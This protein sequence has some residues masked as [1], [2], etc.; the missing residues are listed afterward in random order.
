M[1]RNKSLTLSI[2][3]AAG[4]FVASAAL[5]QSPLESKAHRL[6]AIS[7]D[8]QA[9]GKSRVIVK[10][11]LPP[12][13]LRTK[14]QIAARKD[15]VRSGQDTVLRA[16]FGS[17]AAAE[18]HAL[19]RM[20]IQPLFALSASRAELDRLA[21][22]PRVVAIYRD[23]ISR[24]TLIQ[25][26]PLIGADKLQKVGGTGEGFIVAI[27]DTGVERTHDFISKRVIAGACYG[28]NDEGFAP[29]CK[30]GKKKDEGK[31]AGN[32][33]TVSSS[34]F[35]GTHVAGIAAGKL[36][37]KKKHPNEPKVGVAPEA[38]IFAINV[39]S[40]DGSDLGAFDSDI[41]RGLE[42]VLEH[43]ADFEG[44]QV[45]SAN[46]SLGDHSNN[47]VPCDDEDALTG[48]VNDLREAD[49]ATVIASGNDSS[50]NGVSAPGCISGAI[51]VSSTTKSDLISSFSNLGD[52]VDVL[53]PGSVIRSSV[54]NNQFGNASGTSMA[55]PHVTGAFAALR[56]LHPDASVSDIEAALES[57]G[58]PIT[59]TRPRRH[60]DQAAHPG[61]RRPRGDQRLISARSSAFGG[62]P[63]GSPFFWEKQL[64]C[65]GRQPLRAFFVD[66]QGPLGHFPGPF[67]I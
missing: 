22:D 27:V 65:S 13:G 19:T 51:T 5:A 17:A 11:A 21:A 61:R 20:S 57:T 2:A 41:E 59:D 48:I 36:T 67:G 30:G 1:F 39:F 35:H 37:H 55:T 52:L 42:F 7:A 33:C 25:S 23:N 29:T 10:F 12:S 66:R 31:K 47:T 58:K 53:A 14:T 54:L 3:L 4:C 64:Y 50:R 8:L 9:K 32:P 60:V 63:A 56:S 26:I 46:M 45:A 18:R 34:C 24:P 49:I 62:E 40:F 38:K 15:A 6:G 44:L 28:T 16:A 43:S